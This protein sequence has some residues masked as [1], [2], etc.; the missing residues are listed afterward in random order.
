M[1]CA[2]RWKA[3]CAKLDGTLRVNV[4][5]VSTETGTHLWAERFDVR[6]DGIGYGVDDIVRQIA[7]TL[8]VRIVDTESRA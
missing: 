1:A 2:T 8:N 3:A 7:F 5:L 6:R 4:Q